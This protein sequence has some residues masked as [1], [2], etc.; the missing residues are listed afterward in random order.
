MNL[1]RFMDPSEDDHTLSERCQDAALCITAELV[2][3]GRVG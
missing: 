2:A 3:D 1:R